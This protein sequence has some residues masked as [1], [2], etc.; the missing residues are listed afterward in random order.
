MGSLSMPFAGP[1]LAATLTFAPPAA[2]A[3]PTPQA[4][5][6][7]ALPALTQRAAELVTLLYGQ[8]DIA[9]LFDPA[10]LAQ[11]P[12]A[13]LRAILIQLHASMGKALAVAAIDAVQPNAG[14]IRI[15]CEQ[16]V[17]SMNLAVSPDTPN[18]IVGLLIT[19]TTAPEASLDAVVAALKAEPGLTGFALARLDNGPPAASVSLD[20]DRP[21]AIGSAFKLAI[22]AELIRATNR[23]ERHWDDIITLEGTPLPGGFYT[24]N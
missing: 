2:F 17:I 20:A 13:Q 9:A 23:R 8:G 24:R 1:I 19:G 14:R 5:A 4:A 12:E 22:L 6:M 3:Q 11:V 16:G 18:R 10:F 15:T 21:A 7:Q